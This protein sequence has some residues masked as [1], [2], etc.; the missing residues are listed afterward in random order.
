MG[1][2]PDSVKYI[3]VHCAATPPDMHVD[4]ALIDRWHRQRGFLRIGYHYVITRIGEVQVGRDIND[5]GAHVEGFNSVSVGICLAGGVT[6]DDPRVAQD[7]FTMPQKRAL[8]RLIEKLLIKF[9]KA[10]IVGHRDLNPKKD[11]PS[12]DAKR[13]WAEENA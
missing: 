12:F 8:R 1:L 6:K 2:A 3:V 7:N 11:C 13:W 9:P 4:A 10:E 5:V